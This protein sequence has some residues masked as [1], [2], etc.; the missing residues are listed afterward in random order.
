MTTPAA[1]ATEPHRIARLRHVG[2]YPVPWMMIFNG[3]PD[4]RTLDSEKVIRAA[5]QRL[6]GICG[7]RLG[8]HIVFVGGKN[9]CK[10]GHF[11]DPPFHRECA[12]HAFKICP[13]LLGRTD[14][15]TQRSKPKVDDDMKLIE[16]D[17]A[18][19]DVMGIYQ[20]RTYELG[21]HGDMLLFEAGACEEITYFDRAGK[22]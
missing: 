16:G 5:R 6:C 22:R 1:I 2:G 4:F 21:A 19:S 20:T 13:Y 12:E 7:E 17:V 14:L 18:D 11:V 3:V 15:D 10:A 9:S 8:K